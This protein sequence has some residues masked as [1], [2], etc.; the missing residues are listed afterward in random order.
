MP[1]MVLL[2]WKKLGTSRVDDPPSL[3]FWSRSLDAPCRVKSESTDTP[4]LPLFLPLIYEFGGN[5]STSKRPSSVAL[6]SLRASQCPLSKL[7]AQHNNFTTTYAM[8][9]NRPQ[10]VWQ[11]RERDRKQ[12]NTVPSTELYSCRSISSEF[13]PSHTLPLP[14]FVGI[15]RKGSIR[16]YIPYFALGFKPRVWIYAAAVYIPKKKTIS[17]T[18]LCK[19]FR[20]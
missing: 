14:S 13:R 16:T 10:K 1:D 9:K 15:Q 20:N 5:K 19:L 12:K 3:I 8:A 18:I 4:I 11:A 7:H 17:R 6:F 2:I